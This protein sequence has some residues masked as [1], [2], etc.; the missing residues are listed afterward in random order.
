MIIKVILLK[1][2]LNM[3][4]LLILAALP[5]L[6][7]SAEIPCTYSFT[8]TAISTEYFGLDLRSA[9]EA[10]LSEKNYTYDEH[11][12]QKLSV[13]YQSFYRNSEKLKSAQVQISFDQVYLGLKKCFMVECTV[14]DAQKAA[15]KALKEFKQK[16]PQCAH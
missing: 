14:S 13:N 15:L 3:K 1:E 4:K 16:L 8:K 11:T 9:L 7:F 6:S 10:I 5:L 2:R 12:L